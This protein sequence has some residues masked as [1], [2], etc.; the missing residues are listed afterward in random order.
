MTNSPCVA[1]VLCSAHG[2][3]RHAKPWAGQ[4]DSSRLIRPY[5]LY[6][7]N[8]CCLLTRNGSRVGSAIA[9]ATRIRKTGGNRSGSTGSRWSRS[10]PVHEPVRFPPSH[11]KT[12]PKNSQA[13]LTS[14]FDR[15]TG[16]FL[17]NR[18]NRSSTVLL[19]LGATSRTQPLV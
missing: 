13:W 15:F 12:V 9:G 4:A 10:G 18:G 7:N 11:L 2:P 1:F 16:R 8:M 17:L 3:A 5:I 14:R 6:G 19:T